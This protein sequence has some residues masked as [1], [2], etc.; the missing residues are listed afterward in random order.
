L[1]WG[2]S[3]ELDV[4][5]RFKRFSSFRDQRPGAAEAELGRMRDHAREPD[6][7]AESLP[8]SE[9]AMKKAEE[10]SKEQVPELRA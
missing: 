6:W 2:L 7:Q 10:P 1:E 8:A 4:R 5:Q 3:C 9:P